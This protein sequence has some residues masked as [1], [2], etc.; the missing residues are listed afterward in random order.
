MQ[1]TPKKHFLFIPTKFEESL[2]GFML[3]RRFFGA[4]LLRDRCGT[5]GQTEADE[6]NVVIPHVEHV[7]AV[8]V[9]AG[10]VAEDVGLAVEGVPVRKEGL[11]NFE[12]RG[13]LYIAQ[14]I[15]YFYLELVLSN[16][17]CVRYGDV[18]GAEH[19]RA[20]VF[21]VNGKVYGVHSP[22]R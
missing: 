18:V 22:A 17:Q 19:P 7:V 4:I 21:T 20:E 11:A 10:R 12:V 2:N 9:G 3:F 1:K 14:V 16:A 8:L 13:T 15:Y 6:A 5:V